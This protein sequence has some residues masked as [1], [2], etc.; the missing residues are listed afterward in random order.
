MSSAHPDF[1]LETSSFGKLAFFRT[2]MAC[3]V[4][5]FEW[6][7]QAKPGAPQAKWGYVGTEPGAYLSIQVGF[8]HREG[9]SSPASRKTV[10]SIG[11]LK[12]YRDMGIANISCNAS[13]VAKSKCSCEQKQWNLHLEHR[14]SQVCCSCT[15]LVLGL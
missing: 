10:V 6:V 12:S 5:G 7:N 9:S 3:L 13:S 2:Y 11:M 4:Q 1:G 14:M 8:G 15:S